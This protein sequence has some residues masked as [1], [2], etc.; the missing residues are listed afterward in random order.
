MYRTFSRS[1]TRQ[2]LHCNFKVIVMS[3]CTWKYWKSFWWVFSVIVTCFKDRIQNASEWNLCLT[4]YLIYGED[5]Y[6]HWVLNLP[7]MCLAHPFHPPLFHYANYIWWCVQV[8]KLL[9]MQ[10]SPV[11]HHFLLLTSKY[12][13]S[14]QVFKA[15]QFCQLCHSGWH[16]SNTFVSRE[17]W[18]S[19]ELDHCHIPN[20]SHPNIDSSYCLLYLLVGE[21]G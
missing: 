9:I 17:T 7:S 13:H 3:R 21:P 14:Q 6:W 15:S 2:T 10:S 19:T 18:E 20:D 8:V 1:A 16:W 11:C 5:L 12:S 4:E